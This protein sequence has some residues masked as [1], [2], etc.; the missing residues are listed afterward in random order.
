MSVV[1]ANAELLARE[2]GD[3]KWLKNIQYENERMV[4]L[5]TQLLDLARTEKGNA[6]MERVHFSRLIAGESLPF[7]SIAFEKGMEL[8][9]DIQSD[10]Y[11]EGNPIQLKQIVAILVD[12]AICHSQKNG[13]VKIILNKEQNHACLSVI[14]HGKAIPLEHR[15]KIFERFYRVDEVRNSED[16]HYGLGLA[17][18]KAITTAHQGQIDVLGYNHLVE[19]KV[20]IPML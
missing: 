15:E 8:Y 7:E 16:N 6:Q 12:N 19:F 17:I 2:V 10:I 11:V 1:S 14:N 13:F 9:S 18:A 5:I 3:N 4:M 20:K